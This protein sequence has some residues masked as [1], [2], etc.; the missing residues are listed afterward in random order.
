[1]NRGKYAETPLFYDHSESF[2]HQIEIDS[3]AFV[4]TNI[5]LQFLLRRKTFMEW[6]ELYGYLV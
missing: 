2:T 5:Q 6:I 1:M 4:I 3:H